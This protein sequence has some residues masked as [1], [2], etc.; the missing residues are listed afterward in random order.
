VGVYRLRVSGLTVTLRHRSRDI[1]IL[2]EIFGHTGGVDCYAP[3]IEVAQKLDTV[4]SPKVIDLGANIGLF[5]AYVL[6]RW[7][8]ARIVAFEPDDANAELLERTIAVNGLGN[9]WEAR[10]LACSNRSGTI[11]FAAGRLSESR[12]ADPEETGTIAVHMVDLFEQDHD[13][14]LLK[15]DIEGAEWAILADRRLP[16]LQAKA[17][18]FEWHERGCPE[19]DGH[20]A[21]ERLLRA[22]GY[23]HTRDIGDQSG[24]GVM[25][26][27][28]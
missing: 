24:G 9:H 17:I 12:I 4:A 1:D 18:V 27:W 20:A 7:P 28:R 6:G 3:P 19:A 16:E 5:G 14:D 23:A 8:T 26:A 22:A 10:R 13:V 15:I 21:A 2:N 25:W 11:G